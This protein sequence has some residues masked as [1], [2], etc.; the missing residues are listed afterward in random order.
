MRSYLTHIILLLVSIATLSCTSLESRGKRLQK[1]VSQQC[2]AAETLTNTFHDVLNSATPDSVRHIN[3]D[4]QH[5]VIYIFN[6]TGLCFWTDNT[7]AVS[8]VRMNTFNQWFFQ[9]L[10]N[11]Q[12][13]C[14]WTSVKNFAVLTIVPLKHRYPFENQELQNV[15]FAPFLFLDK[16]YSI[17]SGDNNAYSIFDAS[18]R[19]LFGL[20]HKDLSPADEAQN[21]N[22]RFSDSFSYRSLSHDGDNTRARKIRT[23]YL[24]I[25]LFFSI[26]V[27]YAIYILFRHY[28]RHDMRL[29]DRLQVLFGMVLIASFVIIYAIMV[30]FSRRS[31]EAQQ[32]RD[33]TQKAAY[34]QKFLQETYF[35][36]TTLDA[37]NTQ[38][39]NV[40]LKD[41]SFA[42]HSDIHVYDIFG[43]LIGS[44]QPD[45]FANHIIGHNMAP[46]PYFADKPTCLMSEK[47]SELSYLSAY[48]EFYNGDYE[49]IGYIAVP[50][51]ISSDEVNDAVDSL[52]S[53]L[54]P[55]YLAIAVLSVLL[56]FWLSRQLIRPLK[57]VSDK[58]RDFAI[59]HKNEKIDYADKDEFGQLIGYYNNMVDQLESSLKQLKQAER[60]EAWRTM[61]RQV[62]HEIKNPLT[63][64]RL[65]IQQMQ[66]LKDIDPERF[67]QYFDQSSPLL[68]EQIDN[69]SHIATSFSDFAKMPEPDITTVDVAQ[70]LFAV[71]NLFKANI[72][73]IPINYLGQQQGVI[74]TTDTE[75]I[76]Q[77]LNNLLK[78]AL[79]ALAAQPDPEITVTL[80]TAKNWAIIN[81]IDNGIGVPEDIRDKIFVPNF[82]TKSTGSGLGLAISKH[83]VE[84]SGGKIYFHCDGNKTT[85]TIEL[86]RII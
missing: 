21:S 83:I 82:T 73:E 44:S 28:I 4:N 39:L 62:A 61:A 19:R 58:M 45:L 30:N 55:I 10:N 5:C 52:L 31:Y 1:V 32:R 77:V 20:S 49:L 84:A 14:L 71:V 60:Q 46:K 27:A 11:V 67:S 80:T 16:S 40:S 43:R 17:S 57:L 50:L 48:T 29:T 85:F 56:V 26:Y 54:L 59:G 34:I 23:Y 15:F 2:K 9:D 18:G 6:E 12:A 51:F 65:T 78:N 63:P 75:Q 74:V 70:K 35:F 3:T 86:P 37:T 69:L 81:V 76:T 72:R 13:L 8:D 24:L 36:N 41:L 68:I 38:S 42:Y 33:L 53:R 25:L 64:M 7:L 47:I 79:Q 22:T 66:R